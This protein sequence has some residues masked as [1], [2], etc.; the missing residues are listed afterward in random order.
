ML[1]DMKHK[2]SNTFKMCLGKLILEPKTCIMIKSSMLVK[3]NKAFREYYAKLQLAISLED[4]LQP[5]S[6]ILQS[7]KS[8]L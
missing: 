7:I 4:E 5:L 2:T 6:H 8:A 1:E 3:M